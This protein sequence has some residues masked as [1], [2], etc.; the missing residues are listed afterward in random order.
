MAEKAKKP[1]GPGRSMLRKL[2]AGVLVLLLLMLYATYRTFQKFSGA[3]ERVREANAVLHEVEALGSGLKDAQTGVRSYILTHDTAFLP[4]FKAAQPDVE[5]SMHRLD[6]LARAGVVQEDL[7]TFISLSRMMIKQVQ[8]QFLAE[9]ATGIGLQDGELEQLAVGRDIMER[10]RQEQRRVTGSLEKA[11]DRDLSTERSLRPD[12]PLMLLVFSLLAISATALLFWRLFQALNDAERARALAQAKV[13]ERD[14]EMRTRQFAERSLRSVL[15]SS[16]NSVMACR[17]LRG[18]AGVIED[19]TCFL[20]NHECERRYAGKGGSLVGR[21]LLEV[22]P[23]IKATGLFGRLVEVVQTGTPLEDTV[24]SVHGADN[25]LHI[26]VLR[27]GDGFVITVTDVTETRRAQGL[28]A[29]SDRLAITG[30]IARTIAHEVRN[31]LTNLHLALGQM[32]EEISPADQDAVRPFTEILARNTKRIGNLIDDLLESSK[33]KEVNRSEC[34]VRTLLE[35]TM[36]NVQDR[37]GLLGMKGTVEVKPG[38]ER[39]LGDATMLEVALTNLC[40]NAVEAMDEGRGEL[41]LTAACVD[42]RMRI[43]VQDNGKGIAQENIQRLFQAFYSSR[44]GG[45]GLGLTSARTI[46][47]AHGVHV[48]VQSEVGIGTRFSLTFPAME[49]TMAPS[50]QAG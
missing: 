36:A 39:L 30:G 9:R 48:D 7:S 34:E 47:N 18:A 32:L 29:E 8:D 10:V 13:D 27:L 15:D 23:G 1:S 45:M 24:L 35:R 38:A 41:H 20:A 21:R 6:S 28:L 12:T 50:R 40:I 2:Y 22:V 14:A 43:T 49:D 3:S 4:P 33:P 46:L 16:P 19:F 11:R 25:W 44:S 26:H 37:M 17:S 5:R 42:R 31:P